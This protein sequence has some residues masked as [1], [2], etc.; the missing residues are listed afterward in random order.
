MF[1]VLEVKPLKARFRRC[2]TL[3]GAFAV[4]LPTLAPAVAVAQRPADDAQR[5]LV[6]VFQGADKELGAK[7]AD[8][9]RDKLGKE[10]NPRDVWVIPTTDINNTLT[11]SGYPTNEALG[12][13]DGRQLAIQVR[14]DQYIDGVVTRTPTGYKIE[15]RLVLA[16][17]QTLAQVLPP[18]ETTNLDR[19]ATQV[20]SSI[21]EARRQVAGEQACYRAFREAKYQDAVAA[22]RRALN[23][24][25]NAT[26]AAICLGNA[27]G[28]LKMP[29]SVQS[30]GERIVAKDSKNIPALRW[31]VEIY[32]TKND[33]RKVPTLLQLLAADPTNVQLQ[34]QAVNDIVLSGHPELAVPIITQLVQDNPGDPS[35]LRTG[36]LVFL[37]AKDYERALT[38][39]SELIRVDTAAADTSYYIRTATAYTALNRA[40]DALATMTAGANRFKNN[41]TLQLLTAQTLFKAVP[42]QVAQAGQYLNRVLAIDPKNVNANVILIQTLMDPDA[43]YAAIQKAAAN[44]ADK[45]VL[46]QLAL[47]QA[48]A[49]INQAQ[50]TKARTDYQRA[51]RFAQ[52]SNVLAPSNPDVT[53]SYVSGLAAYYIAEGAITEAVKTKSCSLA[54]MARD[55][56]AI[57]QTT[58]PAAGKAHPSEAGQVLGAV[59]QYA[60]SVAQA[61]KQYCR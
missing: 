5:I 20:V 2:S 26:L 34:Q 1:T 57:V 45:D 13:S 47:Q 4:L 32:G 17:D 58:L 60:P 14:A 11:A 24:S 25:P 28:A 59:Q 55:N 35:I 56:F 12:P 31:L 3:L 19:A 41:I 50:Q 16:R 36:W 61:V 21:K 43:I 38:V 37:A 49:A 53:A 29:D 27:Y 40:A 6:V 51:L 52:L 54:Q 23:D 22:A 33:P 44:G 30:I 46:A 9:I 15:A 48:G 8:A 7:A 10:Y 39:G 18:A 42:P